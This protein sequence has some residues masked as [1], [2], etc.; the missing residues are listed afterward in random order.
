MILFHYWPPPTLL[1]LYSLTEKWHS[2][3]SSSSLP[4]HKVAHTPPFADPPQCGNHTP[5]P[6]WGHWLLAATQLTGPWK[7]HR[8]Q[9]ST[10]SWGLLCCSSTSPPP[11]LVI[12]WAGVWWKVPISAQR[13]QNKKFNLLLNWDYLTSFRSWAFRPR[14]AQQTS[15]Q[16]IWHRHTD[17]LWQV[18]GSSF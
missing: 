18:I 6:N 8:P 15:P 5:K 14:R 10:R 11:L 9:E 7:L 2:G 1:C 13:K 4:Y 16:H 12:L 17:R 3:W